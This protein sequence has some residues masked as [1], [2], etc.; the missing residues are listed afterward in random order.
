MRLVAA[1]MVDEIRRHP[2][3]QVDLIGLF[4]DLYLDAVPAALESLTLYLEL[5]V[6]SDDLGRRHFLRLRLLGPNGGA[7]QAESRINFALPDDPELVGRAVPLD[8]TL[9]QLTLTAFGG[10][11][12]EILVDD[13]LEP[14]RR[15][16]LRVAPKPTAPIPS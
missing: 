5:L 9:F 6:E 15:L 2:D 4:E 11:T 3:G 10:H 7:V 16:T 1:L 12:L 13:A 14:D 8:P